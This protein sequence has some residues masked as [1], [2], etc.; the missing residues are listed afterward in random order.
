MKHNWARA[1]SSLSLTAVMLLAPVSEAMAS[2]IG[3]WELDEKKN[4]WMYAI[5]P[6]EYL[7]EQW[8]TEDGKEYY[9]D[10]N[11]YMK[12]GWFT[13]KEDGKKY[14]L[15]TD[16]AKCYNC[17]TPDDKYVGPEGTQLELFDKYRKAVKKELA[18]FNK[19]NRT[20]NKKGNQKESRS[21]AFLLEDFNN[22]GY[23]DFA[24]M[25]CEATEDVRN[26]FV[27]TGAEA[28]VLAEQAERANREVRRVQLSGQVISPERQA[29]ADS[30]REVLQ[31]SFWNPEQQ[32]FIIASEAD[33]DETGK[34]QSW[35]A[36][37]EHRDTAWLMMEDGSDDSFACYSL[38][39]E[40]TYFG[41]WYSFTVGK[42]QWGDKLW[43]IDGFE[44]E[45]CVW[46]EELESV[47][48]NAGDSLNTRFVPLTEENMNQAADRAPTK[49]EIFLWTE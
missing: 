12:T 5:D 41:Q 3:F 25:S 43:F 8:L 46:K 20:G 23:R 34:K 30:L 7:R 36:V 33:P 18:A 32:K 11:G 47:K 40:G 31:V 21:Y 24:V 29:Y 42:N 16:G 2:E 15:G 27:Q 45:K 48:K 28:A 14:Y 13:D 22:D 6:G 19:G 39:E 4:C 26:A 17:F 9:L 35:L 10:A 49:E 38:E 37:S 1:I 44:E